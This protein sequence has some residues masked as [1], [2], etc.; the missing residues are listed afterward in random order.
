MIYP[1]LSSYKENYKANL[2]AFL[3]QYEDNTET[4]FRQAEKRKYKDYQNAL[5]KIANQLYSSTQDESN[6][7]LIQRNIATDLKNMDCD[8]YTTIITEL[9]PVPEQTILSISVA[10][11]DRI[12]VDKPALEHHIKSSIVILKFISNKKEEESNRKEI[13][14]EEFTIDSELE[15]IAADLWQWYSDNSSNYNQI[16][17]CGIIEEKHDYIIDT[18]KN[19]EQRYLEH[20]LKQCKYFLN[21]VPNDSKLLQY[22]KKLEEKLIELRLKCPMPSK[23]IEILINEINNAFYRLEKFMKGTISHYEGFL[24]NDA[25]TLLTNELSKIENINIKYNS[26]GSEYWSY[27]NQLAYAF[28]KGEF[29]NHDAYQNKDFDRD[30]NEISYIQWYRMNEIAGTSD[31][32]V[33]QFEMPSIVDI[34]KDLKE[35]PNHDIA[36]KK[37]T[38]KT[39][40]GDKWHALLYLIEIEVYKKQIP[41]NVDGAFIKSEIEQIG[42]HRCK[43]SGQGFYRQVRDMKGNIK[44]NISVKRLFN[45]GWKTVVIEMSNNDE[46]IIKYLDTF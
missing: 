26:I 21:E 19:Y 18:Y 3:N 23:N 20:H 27:M 46:N 34:V 30:S 24:F 42:K 1:T 7:V 29:E 12:Q 44:D 11:K 8:I 45:E 41:T 16:S 37:T 15:Q 40:I 5:T 33:S 4:F 36:E 39:K 2:M 22:K 35:E 43:N 10:K 32:D 38:Q 13:I 9:D 17:L 6:T 25:F 28:D 31:A 14:E